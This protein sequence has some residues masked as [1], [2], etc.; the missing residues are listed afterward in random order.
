MVYT[1]QFLALNIIS[2]QFVTLKNCIA[3]LIFF[4]FELM[5][6]PA[7]NNLLKLGLIIYAFVMIGYLIDA[8]QLT[9]QWDRDGIGVPRIE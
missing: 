4:K 2:F 9:V 6:S 1:M 8:M 5:S 7:S 3:N